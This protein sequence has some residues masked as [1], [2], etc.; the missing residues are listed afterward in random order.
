MFLL[1]AGCADRGYVLHPS[2]QDGKPKWPVASALYNRADGLCLSGG[3]YRAVAYETG[4]ILAANRLGLLERIYTI[5]GVSGGAIVAAQLGLAWDTLN[6]PTDRPRGFRE[7]TDIN[8]VFA[9]P[10]LE[11][12]R[13]NIDKQAIIKGALT[14]GRNSGYFV[15]KA[16][17][18]W[19][20]NGAKLSALSV[21]GPIV[22]L[23]S[24]SLDFAA[25]WIFSL[26]GIGTYYQGYVVD[27]TFPISLAVAASSA[28]PPL[29]GPIEIAFNGD[30]FR[31]LTVVAMDE[32]EELARLAPDPNSKVKGHTN[33]VDGGVFNNLGTDYCLIEE[34][35]LLVD[36]EA[37]VR[38]RNA[39][40][41]DSST[42]DSIR[43]IETD[44]LHVTMRSIDVMYNRAASLVRGDIR[45][46][47]RSKHYEKAVELADTAIAQG[48]LRIALADHADLFVFLETIV[49]NMSKAVSLAQGLST[50]ERAE[51]LAEWKGAASDLAYFHDNLDDLFATAGKV[52][53]RLAPLSECER[54]LLSTLGYL[55][56][57]AGLWERWDYL[58]QDAKLALQVWF[59]RNSPRVPEFAWFGKECRAPKRSAN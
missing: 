19:L 33:L 32:T 52:Q 56:I 17:D 35:K 4:A 50:E 20:F 44:Y 39:I 12:T 18:Q 49:P 34:S 43:P 5:S 13:K 16:Y 31:A 3:G 58:D 51:Y 30:D 23:N 59:V 36:D 6:F 37:R 2:L 55:Q 42:P 1:F 24:T 10:L 21:H 11:L 28:Y 46:Q 41:V 15:A 7:A 38:G 27:N 29:L 54:K 9:L 8:K 45:R 25:P 47:N 53:T 40:L 14:P 48:P 57:Y 22:V 26:A